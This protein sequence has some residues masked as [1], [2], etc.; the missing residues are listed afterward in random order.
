MTFAGLLLAAAVVLFGAALATTL[1]SLR[2]GLIL[3]I[4]AGLTAAASMAIWSAQPSDWDYIGNAPSQW[5][6]DVAA[7]KSLHEAMAETASWYDEMIAGNELVIA[8]AATTMRR[9]VFIAVLTTALGT[10]AAGTLALV[11]R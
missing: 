5:L 8:S 7:G 10:I 11:N 4:G 6:Q 1:P 9:A 2:L 3:S